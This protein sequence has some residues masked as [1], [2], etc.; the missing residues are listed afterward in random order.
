MRAV[1]QRVSSAQVTVDD[2][3]VGS[4]EGGLLVLVGATHQDTPD[5]VETVARKIAGLRVFRDDEG[6]MNR[7]VH[8]VGGSVMVV[9]QFTLY[10]SVR[11]G[12]RPSFVDAAPPEIAEPLIELLIA[13]LRGRGIEVQTGRFGAMMDV[14]LVNDGPVTVV[15]ETSDGAIL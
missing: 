6:K 11:R 15:I 9:S 7:S 8:E 5:D 13:E 4:V 14:A 2:V 10:A 12:R 3:V 1:V